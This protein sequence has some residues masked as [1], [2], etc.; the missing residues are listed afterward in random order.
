[1]IQPKKS[2]GQHF[3]TDTN[4]ARK[5][6]TSLT[7]KIQC[8]A[9]LEVGPGMGILTE[10]LLQD[11]KLKT[12]IVEIDSRA[13]EFLKEKF[14]YLKEH[15]ITSDF[16]KI[17]L[18]TVFNRDFALIGNFPY[19]ISSQILFKVLDHRNQINLVV[20]MFQKEVGERIS[21]PPGTKK[22]G[23]LSVLMQAF[24]EVEYLFSVNPSVFNPPPKVQSAVLRFRR[25][26]IKKL[27]CN[28]KLFF[29]V[30]KTGFNQRRKTLRNALKTLIDDP[31]ISTGALFDN[32]AEQLSVSQF[33]E[34]TNLLDKS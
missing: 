30:V 33:I 21:K 18:S 4:I 32:R 17:D 31:A 24:Y 27:N 26:S 3:L 14:P 23:I 29:K 34:L 13:A 11:P 28:E 20:G 6:V 1:M 2:L 22:Y 9:V 7:E 5:I 8:S 16:L 25:N 15:L 12:K 10:L 19:N